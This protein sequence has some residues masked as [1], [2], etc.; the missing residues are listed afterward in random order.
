MDEDGAILDEIRKIGVSSIGINVVVLLA[1]RED[2][3]ELLYD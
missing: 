1:N 2:D 3:T